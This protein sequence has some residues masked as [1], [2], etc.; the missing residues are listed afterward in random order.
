M[1]ARPNPKQNRP[2]VGRPDRNLRQQVIR[3]PST[4]M[5]YPVR[6]KQP[7]HSAPDRPHSPTGSDTNGA[8]VTVTTLNLVDDLPILDADQRRAKTEA[9]RAEFRRQLEQQVNPDGTLPP[10][11]VAAR[12]KQVRRQLTAEAGRRSGEV[13]R[14]KAAGRKIAANEAELERLAQALAL[15]EAS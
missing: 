15:L 9:A 2:N 6:G 3:S 12:L 11:E 10:E 8:P 4:L 7:G 1:D 5:T 13:R 14:A